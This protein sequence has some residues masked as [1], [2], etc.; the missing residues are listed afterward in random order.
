MGINAYTVRWMHE[1]LNAGAFQGLNSVLELGPQDFHFEDDVWVLENLIDSIVSDRTER[2]AI[3]ARV[4]STNDKAAMAGLD[5]TEKCTKN[6]VLD[7][8]VLFGMSEYVSMDLGDPRAALQHDLNFPVD[9]GRQFG[10]VTNF[11]TLEHVFNIGQAF[12][13]SH[14]SLVVGGLALHVLPTF[15]DYGHGFYNIHANL[16]RSMIDAN[17]YD[18]LA[19]NVVHDVM[20]VAKDSETPGGSN[21]T[22]TTA[23]AGDPET[24][25]LLYNVNSMVAARQNRPGPADHLY[26][27]YHKR[28]E[29]PFVYPQQDL[30]KNWE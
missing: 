2:E 25:D 26:V 29:R 20:S 12:K 4:F 9:I 13:T 30:Y 15:G 14:D 17:D 27:A 11:G 3:Y 6:A 22:V 8:Y 21:P 16:F 1:L 18:P 19:L 24:L 28:H 7:Y 23:A 5:I 10:V